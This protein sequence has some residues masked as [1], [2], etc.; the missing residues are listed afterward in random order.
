MYVDNR[1]PCTHLPAECH[2]YINIANSRTLVWYLKWWQFLHCDDFVNIFRA[3]F[4]FLDDSSFH[5][6][7]TV[8][9]KAN[10][11]T[12]TLCSLSIHLSLTQTDSTANLIIV[13]VIQEL[14]D[15]TF[16]KHMTLHRKTNQKVYK[17]F[18][19][20]KIPPFTTLLWDISCTKGW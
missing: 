17:Y 4:Q 5:V 19:P 13:K 18:F 6:T 15:Y 11:S 20:L 9:F 16:P 7:D 12:V 2:D 8:R 3:E 10:T 1:L 14:H